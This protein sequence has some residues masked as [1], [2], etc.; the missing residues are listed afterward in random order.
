MHKL[1][2]Y[3]DTTVLNFAFADDAPKEMEDTLKFFKQIDRFEVSISDIVLDEI[4]R[5]P[6]LKRGRLMEII[7]R[8]DWEILELDQAA[9]KLAEHYLSAGVIPQKYRDDAYHIAIATVNDQDA[10]L[11]WNFEHIVKM[12]TKREVVAIN[13][14][15][16]YRGIDI[17]TPKEVVD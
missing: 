14:L 4:E 10:I 6:A 5:C 8:H 11:S 16:G 3:L 15:E 17:Y 7:T 9:R 13:L 2:L 12:K 1:K